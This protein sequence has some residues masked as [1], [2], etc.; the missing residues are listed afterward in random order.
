M[1]SKLSC[2]PCEVSHGGL[3]GRAAA[4]NGRTRSCFLVS[5]SFDVF[6]KALPED[7]RISFPFLG[8]CQFEHASFWLYKQRTFVSHGQMICLWGCADAANVLRS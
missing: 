2:V 6:A 1:I 7:R 4:C 8:K 3:R 5:H